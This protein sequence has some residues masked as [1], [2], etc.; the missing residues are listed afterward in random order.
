[1]RRPRRPWTTAEVIAAF[2]RFYSETGKWPLFTDCNSTNGLPYHESV[3]RL[4]GTLAE[5]RRQAG[6]PGGG[7]EGFGRW[8]A[9]LFTNQK[10]QARAQRSHDHA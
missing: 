10:M 9:H 6:M 7:W 4:F 8:E 3:E 1:M 2:Q 5:A